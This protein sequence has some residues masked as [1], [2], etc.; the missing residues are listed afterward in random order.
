MKWTRSRLPVLKGSKYYKNVEK[1]YNFRIKSET[2]KWSV[3][4]KLTGSCLF[5]HRNVVATCYLFIWY[6][7]ILC[8]FTRLKH[9]YFLSKLYSNYFSFPFA[10]LVSFF[11]L[12]IPVSSTYKSKYYKNVEKTHNF[13]I[14]SETGKGK[15]IL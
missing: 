6:K 2:G 9:L 12:G 13:R 14:K 3:R 7:I 4:G 8:Y 15:Q 5:L 10:L 11:T 1:A